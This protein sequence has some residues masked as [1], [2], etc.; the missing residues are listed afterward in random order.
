M[1]FSGN[2]IPTSFKAELF[3][4][5]HVMTASGGDV[6][7]LALYTNSAALDGSTAVYTS[8]GE[9]VGTNYPAGGQALTNV[10]PMTGGTTGYTQFGNLTFS[11]VTL[12]ARGCMIYNSSKGNKAVII[13]DFGSDKSATSGDF[14]ITMPVF[15]STTALIRLT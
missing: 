1:A 14:I 10:D 2:V 12:T 4:A 3:T 8:T 5:I 7:K 11:N 15:S 6:F 13:V 9:V